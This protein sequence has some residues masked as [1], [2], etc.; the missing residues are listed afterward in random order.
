M[1]TIVLT[2]V[3]TVLATFAFAQFPQSE[4]PDSC[5][6]VS[7][8]LR[9]AIFMDNE[10]YV[11]VKIAKIPGELIKIRVKENNNVLYLK[12]IKKWAVADVKY[13]ISQFP[14]GVYEFEILK[15]NKVVFTK[16]IERGA[17]VCN[18]VLNK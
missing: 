18:Y 12:R 6:Y 13:D 4:S 15:D 2:I 17:P 11:N 7:E 3:L 1:K 16:T 14:E 8:D 10:S 5:C 9:V